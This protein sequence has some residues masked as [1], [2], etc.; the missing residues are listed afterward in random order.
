MIDGP[1]GQKFPSDGKMLVEAIGTTED[2]CRPVLP[3]EML[4]YFFSN[5]VLLTVI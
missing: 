4:N 2:D 3:T 5:V 1:R